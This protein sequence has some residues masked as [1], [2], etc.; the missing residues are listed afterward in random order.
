M[1]RFLIAILVVFI[2]VLAPTLVSAQDLPM[3]GRGEIL[4]LRRDDPRNQQGYRSFI[5]GGWAP[6]MGGLATIL[7]RVNA[8]IE[9]NRLITIEQLEAANPCL[10]IYHRDDRHAGRNGS[11]DANPTSERLEF[12]AYCQGAQSCSRWPVSNRVYRIPARPRLTPGERAE[13][14]VSTLDRTTVTHTVPAP[15]ELG[16]WM[17]ELSNLMGEEQAPSYDQVRNVLAAVGRTLERT[18]ATVNGSSAVIAPAPVPAVLA[19]AVV[20][21]VVP[22]VAQNTPMAQPT[23]RPTSV[24]NG[25]TPQSSM[26]D[27]AAASTLAHPTLVWLIFALMSVALIY[28]TFKDKILAWYRPTSTNLHSEKPNAEI[29]PPS[30]TKEQQRDKR[31]FE[32][33]ERLWKQYGKNAALTEEGLIQ[34]FVNASSLEALVNKYGNDLVARAE[35]LEQLKKVPPKVEYIEDTSRIKELEN[36]ILGAKAHSL[37]F[38]IELQIAQS[39]L[40]KER[41]LWNSERAAL[42]S[43][44]SQY[45]G[46]LLF[47]RAKAKELV[48][49]LYQNGIVNL[50]FALDQAANTGDASAPSV[51]KA[52]E[53]SAQAR[54]L[55]QEMVHGIL[56]ELLIFVDSD[57]AMK[58]VAP[59]GGSSLFN[60]V[61]T[62]EPLT[63]SDEEQLDFSTGP[64][65][66]SVPE[67]AGDRTHFGP[68][69]SDAPLPGETTQ[70]GVGLPKPAEA[71]DIAFRISQHAPPPSAPKKSKRQAERDERRRRRMTEPIE[72]P[73]ADQSAVQVIPIVGTLVNTP[74]PNF[75]P[76][77]EDHGAEP[78]H[79]QTAVTEAASNEDADITKVIRVTKD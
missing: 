67:L 45:Q 53:R 39:D 17:T 72:K 78:D 75:A 13:E 31:Y 60:T 56:N 8:D 3:P 27:G 79:R 64:L 57:L 51:F 2:L 18:P 20:P 32:S 16:G 47:F 40:A 14:M 22:S 69:P 66:E 26:L 43:E 5:F 42:A 71:E 4:E 11:C 25:N 58:P 70:T 6:R 19:P 49:S 73:S 12:D 55:F 10:V 33:L 34:Y 68:V 15:A 65:D 62:I 76:P 63:P 21:T 9:G 48:E 46:G 41:E 28:L 36:Q 77:M 35:E 30:P 24:E 7:R 38:Q 61:V 37:N 44:T 52:I 23:S 1:S 74:P 50:D 54:D 59:V 29:T